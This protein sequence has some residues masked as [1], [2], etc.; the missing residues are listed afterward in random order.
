MNRLPLLIV[1]LLVLVFGTAGCEKTPLVES[2]LLVP[3]KVTVPWS[4][5]VISGLTPPAIQLLVNGTA[6]DITALEKSTI[7]YSIDRQPDQPGL[8]QIPVDLAKL[9]LPEGIT[10]IKATPS[11][12]TL[13]TEAKVTKRVTVTPQLEGTPAAGL[14]ITEASVTPVTAEIAGGASRVA[15]LDQITTDPIAID[16]ITTTLNQPDVKL[17]VPEGV[18]LVGPET[19]EV[20]VLLSVERATRTWLSLAI[21]TRGTRHSATIHPNKIALTVRGPTVALDR[22][23]EGR[24]VDLFVDLTGLDPGVYVR[25]AVIRLPLEVTLVKAKPALFTITISD[26]PKS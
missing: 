25:R 12:V 19:V 4:D 16:N 13:K 8:H 26:Q 1:A 22:L 14:T 18:T 6:T 20:A 5:Q 11:T 23:N 10:A 2:T 24:A 3:L 15:Q 17:V 7:T 21:A 9:L